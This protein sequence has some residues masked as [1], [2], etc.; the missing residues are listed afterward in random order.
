MMK[1]MPGLNGLEAIE[2]MKKEIQKD[3]KFIMVTAYDTFNYAKQAIKLGAKDYLL[4]PS[5]VSEITQTVGGI[6]EQI[7]A[8]QN[9]LKNEERQQVHLEKSL[10][11]VET[12]IVTQ[13]LFDHVHDVHVNMLIDMLSV[14]SQDEKFV[15]IVHAP[16]EGLN[17]YSTLVKEIKTRGNALVGPL[18]GQQFPVIVFRDKT[19]TY[20]SQASSLVLQ[21]LK[22]LERTNDQ[23]WLVGIGGV[24][25]SFNEMK[26]SYHEALIATMDTSRPVRYR[27][28]S[29]VSER[30]HICDQQFNKYYQKEFFDHI[31]LGNWVQIQNKIA[32]LIHCYEK[33]G[34]SLRKT[35]QRIYEIFWTLFFTLD[36]MGIEIDKTMISFKGQ[37]FN[38]LLIETEG[39]IK[40]VEYAQQSFHNQ[41]HVDSIQQIKKYIIDHSHQDIS[42]ELLADEMGFSPIYISKMFKEKLGVNYIDFLTECRIEKAKELIRNPQKSIKEIALESGYHDPNYFSKVFKKVTGMS[43]KSYQARVFGN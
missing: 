22:K 27:F 11:V 40:Q 36:E 34:A 3:I 5:K 6:L 31:H 28:F 14:Q 30:D 24:Y 23:N 38:Q 41:R 10:R 39:L 16:E 8:D 18:H 7:K 4:K 19:K 33:E 29:D 25:T 20:R 43:P 42:L 15:I 37:T 9:R 1:L 21:V 32:Q 17:Y 12:D 26:K 2:L 13:L 35:Q